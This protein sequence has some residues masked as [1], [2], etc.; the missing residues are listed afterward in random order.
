MAKQPDLQAAARRVFALLK[1]HN[2]QI[3]FAESCTG[4]LIS[5]AM[6]RIPGVSAYHCGS[7]VVYQVETKVAWL[8][9][10]KKLLE[11]RGPVSRQVA[12][13]MAE[14]ALART[15][16]ANLAASVT[17]HLGPDSPEG[18][19]GLIYAAVALR[20]AGKKGTKTVVRKHLL[21]QDPAGKPKSGTKLRIR[22]QTSA[23]CY[24]LSFCAET[25]E[26]L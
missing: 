7:A 21:E 26:R 24:V 1:K 6:T 10:P 16:Q 25:I 3:V 12:V 15:P 13:K 2:L 11:Q 23:A 18:Q 5:A 19:D 14:A 17:G 20:G 4:G 8:G 9:V 22:R